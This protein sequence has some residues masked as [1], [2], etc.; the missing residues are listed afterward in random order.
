MGLMTETPA[1]ENFK[2]H[3]N[4]KNF[5][6]LFGARRKVVG[7]GQFNLVDFLPEVSK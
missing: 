2:K 6:N 4:L 3:K 7:K 5:L 1:R